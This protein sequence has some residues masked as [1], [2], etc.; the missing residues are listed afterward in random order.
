MAMFNTDALHQDGNDLTFLRQAVESN[1][2]GAAAYAVNVYDFD[3]NFFPDG[4][5][6]PL[7]RACELGRLELARELVVWGANVHVQPEDE[8]TPN[9]HE[10]VVRWLN[11]RG[12]QGGSDIQRGTDADRP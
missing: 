11:V 4:P 9:G 6:V 10:D 8:Y 12:I 2:I 3:L 1:K 5:G 7:C